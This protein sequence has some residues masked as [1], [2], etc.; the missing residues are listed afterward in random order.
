MCTSPWSLWSRPTIN[1]LEVPVMACVRLGRVP[2][3]EAQADGHRMFATQSDGYSV[4]LYYVMM[5]WSGV[6]FAHSAGQSFDAT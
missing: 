3:G 1:G 4:T 2:S 6:L 5:Y